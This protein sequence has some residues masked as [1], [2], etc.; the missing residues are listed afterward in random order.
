[1]T[2]FA[3]QRATQHTPNQD[4]FSF[5]NQYD[6]IYVGSKSPI[7]KYAFEV[8]I[9]GTSGTGLSVD[10]YNGSAWSSLVLLGDHNTSD[11]HNGH[12]ISCLQWCH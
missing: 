11:G 3:Q 10:F 5:M 2:P 7:S 1:L 9:A 12:F 8:G 4:Q 6:F